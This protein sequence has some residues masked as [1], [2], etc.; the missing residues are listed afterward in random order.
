MFHGRVILSELVNHFKL[1]FLINKIG[2]KSL[3]AVWELWMQQWLSVCTWP[4]VSNSGLFF[5]P[6]LAIPSTFIPLCLILGVFSPLLCEIILLPNDGFPSLLH[7][8]ASDWTRPVGSTI[9]QRSETQKRDIGF[10]NLFFLWGL[11]YGSGCPTVTLAPIR[12]TSL[13][14]PP[15]L[16]SHTV[17]T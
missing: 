13:Q 4:K 17:K 12:D 10:S 15:S 5:Q 11:F 9:S 1:K 16:V 14:F 8:K 6:T 2:G 3:R 7:W